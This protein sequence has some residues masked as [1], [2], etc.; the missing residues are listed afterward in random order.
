MTSRIQL[1][2]A[3]YWALGNSNQARCMPTCL[4]SPLWQTGEGPDSAGTVSLPSVLKTKPQRCMRALGGPSSKLGLTCTAGLRLISQNALKG[5]MLQ[6]TSQERATDNTRSEP[7]MGG[8]P[9]HCWS[10]PA[11]ATLLQDSVTSS[12]NDCKTSL[13]RPATHH[14]L[15]GRL[16]CSRH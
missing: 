2:S 14:T 13:T 8:S 7:S 4:R 5:D 1:S 3:S 15:S 16:P 11:G 12:L 9:P 6:T 10:P